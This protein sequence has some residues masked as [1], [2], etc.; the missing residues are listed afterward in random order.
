MKKITNPESYD[1]VFCKLC[2]R[3]AKLADTLDGFHACAKCGGFGF[4]MKEK[5][6][7]KKD[8][9][10]TRRETSLYDIQIKK[11]AHGG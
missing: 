10:Y 2:K 9:K 5:R 3:D 6:S 4:I 7:S 11:A 1:I 8:R